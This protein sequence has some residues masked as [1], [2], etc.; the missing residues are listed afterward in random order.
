MGGWKME[1]VEVNTVSPAGRAAKPSAG[2]RGL[3]RQ[4]TFRQSPGLRTG[5]ARFSCRRCAG[6]W[7]KD[8]GP[9]VLLSQYWK[10]WASWR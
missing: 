9:R 1:S 6:T 8:P 7:N 2:V 3:S 10:N 4:R 5:G